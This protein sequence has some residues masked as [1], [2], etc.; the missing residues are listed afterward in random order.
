MT[1]EQILQKVKE[2]EPNEQKRALYRE[3][4]ARPLLR[5]FKN[6]TDDNNI[7]VETD[8]T[9][10]IDLDRDTEIDLLDLQKK[11]TQVRKLA[12]K[13]HCRV[14]GLNKAM[15]KVRHYYP[16]YKQEIEKSR[17]IFSK[18]AD[19][20]KNYTLHYGYYD[21]IFYMQYLEPVKFKLQAMHYSNTLIGRY[22]YLQYRL[23]RA[24]RSLQNESLATIKFDF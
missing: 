4:L 15:A 18:L 13:Q 6:T 5:G 2:L 8:D 17:D 7:C 16:D 24:I 23:D 20:W 14:L 19:G 1:T 11:A 3:Y 10:F 22:T 12:R 21:D 9:V